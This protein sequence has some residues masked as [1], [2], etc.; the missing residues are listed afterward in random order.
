[1]RKR[2]KLIGPNPPSRKHWREIMDKAAEFIGSDYRNSG[3]V[4][5]AIQHG[6]HLREELDEERARQRK[7][8]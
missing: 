8:A 3:V 6:E 1:M 5:A 2:E 7:T 4:L